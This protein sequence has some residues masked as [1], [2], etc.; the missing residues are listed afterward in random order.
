M[1]VSQT[2]RLRELTLASLLVRELGE[3]NTR[4]GFCQGN[5]SGGHLSIKIGHAFMYVIHMLDYTMCKASSFGSCGMRAALLCM[6]SSSEQRL[7]A[8]Q[9]GLDTALIKVLGSEEVLEAH[10]TYQ[11]AVFN[12][13]STCLANLSIF[14]LPFFPHLFDLFLNPPS[15]PILSLLLTLPCPLPIFLSLHF[16]PFCAVHAKKRG[17]R[18]ATVKTQDTDMSVTFLRPIAAVKKAS[19]H[20]QCARNAEL[21]AAFS[22]LLFNL[23]QMAYES[24]P[25]TCTEP[26]PYA[27]LCLEE[28]RL[29]R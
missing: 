26:S 5:N 8:S 29:Q 6:D 20:A 11:L 7:I 22:S 3:L 28:T 18:L 25:C 9:S 17:A 13:Y 4:L 24:Q 1:S 16:K 27:P 12:C 15:P 10:S 21:Q 14:L 2:S 19:E 23:R